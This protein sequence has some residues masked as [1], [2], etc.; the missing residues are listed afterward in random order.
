MTQIILGPNTLV[1]SVLHEALLNTPKEFYQQTTSQLQRN[2][3]YLS[4]QLS[5][6]PG[7]KIIKPGGAMYMMVTTFFKRVFFFG[8]QIAIISLFFQTLVWS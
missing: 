3:V 2:A 5:Q 6:I 1:Q 4:E 7:L 8:S